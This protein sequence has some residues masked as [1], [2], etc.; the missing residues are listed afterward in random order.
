MR[1]Q[2]L[3]HATLIA[4]L[5]GRDYLIDP[6]L[7]PA[8]AWDPVRNSANPRRNPLVELPLATPELAAALDRLAGVFVTHVHADHWDQPAQQALR[9]DLPLFCQPNDRGT[10]EA[11]G[12]ERVM[13]VDDDLSWESLRV[14]RTGGQHGTGE[15]AARIGPVSGFVIRAPGE[16]ALYVAGDT[17]WCDEVGAALADHRPEVVVVNAGSAQFLDSDPITMDADDVVRVARAA[18]ESRVLAVHF[19]AINHCGLTRRSLRERL[20]EEGLEK[21]VSVPEN[22]D[23]LEF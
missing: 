20:V 12:F 7:S 5:A 1:L 4:R 17:I 18:P 9:K 3:R 19:E 10:I 23:W 8:G 13:P 2:L 15:V 22:G 11:A 14:S 21:R 6:M 16:P